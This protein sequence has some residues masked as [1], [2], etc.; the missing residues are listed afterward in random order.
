MSKLTLYQVPPSP[1]CVKIRLALGLKQLDYTTVDVGFEDRAQVIEVSGQ[2]LTPVLTDGERVIYDSR[3][4]D[5]NWKEGP[6]L[7][8]ADRARQQEIQTWEQFAR[9]ELG[10]VM[11]MIVGQLF[12]GTEDA[13]VL[14]KAHGLLG[15]RLRRVEDALDGKEF[16]MGTE[17]PSAADLTCAAFSLYGFMDDTSN[18][19]CAIFAK[20]ARLPDADFPRTAAWLARCLAFDA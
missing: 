3:Y 11:G 15:E 4:L 20:H 8:D 2:P 6:R 9:N 13:E 5:A 10:E 1:N 14:G 16:L 19:V 12:A 7:F 18:P 17:A